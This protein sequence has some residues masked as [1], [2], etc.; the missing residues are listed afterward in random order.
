MDRSP[1]E[2]VEVEGVAHLHHGD[3]AF[4]RATFGGATH[5]EQRSA[6]FSIKTDDGTIDIHPPASLDG[7]LLPLDKTTGTWAEIVTPRLAKLESIAPAPDVRIVVESVAITE[8]SVVRVRGRVRDVGAADTAGDYRD[9]PARRVTA[10]D[11]ELIAV[12]DHRQRAIDAALRATAPRTKGRSGERATVIAIRIATLIPLL[13]VIVRTV[14]GKPAYIGLDDA[15]LAADDHFVD[16]RSHWSLP[17][18]PPNGRVIVAGRKL[19]GATIAATQPGNL[20]IWGTRPDGNPREALDREVARET[21]LVA[22]L[23]AGLLAA[24][25]VTIVL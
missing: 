17:A 2:V 4:E 18:I 15:Q 21:W 5:V 9:A 16:P 7:V 6:R 25:V 3:V 13:L 1:G 8:G 20:V 23:A 22:Q 14:R 11:A 19:S 10:L 24:I 12:G